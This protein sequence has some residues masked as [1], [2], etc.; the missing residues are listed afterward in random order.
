M[1]KPVSLL[2]PAMN[3]LARG[4]DDAV[5]RRPK[6]KAVDGVVGLLQALILDRNLLHPSQMEP[7]P[8]HYRQHVLHIADDGLF[9][10]VALVWLPHQETPVHDH[11]S[12]CVVGV[13]QGA[14][15]ETNYRRDDDGELVEN[16][17]SFH[18][19]GTVV[20]L[21][22]PVDIH[23]VSNGCSDV[24]ISLHVYGA[25]ISRSGTSIKRRYSPGA[26]PAIEFHI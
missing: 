3:G 6:G 8:D 24:A 11:V 14:E 26:E 25:D 16:G 15:I 17:Y 7:D 23:K 18:P 21:M 12:W 1:D 4:I 22:P 20:G 2:T 5:R 10:I 9:S 13:H 19:A